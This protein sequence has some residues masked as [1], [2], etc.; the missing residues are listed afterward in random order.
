MPKKQN[1]KE[2]NFDE[3]DFEKMKNSDEMKKET[4]SPETNK[5]EL[6]KYQEEITALKDK[7][8]RSYAETENIRRRSDKELQDARKFS[9]T[10]VVKDLV[11]V[12][13]SLYRSTEHITE[14]DKEDEKVKKV[15]EGIELTRK[16]LMSVLSKNNVK[17]VVP[18]VG[19][20]FDHTVHQAISQIAD[21]DHPKNSIIKIIQAGYL[22]EDRLIK[23]ALVLV[24]AGKEK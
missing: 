24:S 2:I 14:E 11:N 9:I 16:E 20:V 5:E 21:N 6:K 10:G 12:I 1:K 17:R 7:C 8:L 13:E 22:I 15:V 18:K 3:I 23:P 19:D 4:E